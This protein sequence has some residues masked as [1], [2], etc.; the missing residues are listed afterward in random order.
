MS[1]PKPIGYVQ[2]QWRDGRGHW[3][4]PG[5]PNSDSLEVLCAA[6]QPRLVRLRHDR[7]KVRIEL[8]PDQIRVEDRE[9]RLVRLSLLHS[10]PIP[11]MED[12]KHVGCSFHRPTFD[13]SQ[14]FCMAIEVFDHEDELP[15]LTVHFFLDP[16]ERTMPP[17]IIMSCG[18]VYR[19]D[20][21]LASV[22][23]RRHE[24]QCDRR[25]A[26]AKNLSLN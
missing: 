11:L 7:S 15:A 3:K 6:L 1:N 18:L 26:S 9:C 13:R 24:E 22:F 20:E 21:L 2:L 25:H 14:F 8:G 19:R 17:F 23:E 5:G 10:E 4:K 16:E 12:R